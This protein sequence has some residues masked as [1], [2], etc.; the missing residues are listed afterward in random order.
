[1]PAC[2][3][4]PFSLLIQKARA[5][6]AKLKECSQQRLRLDRRDGDDLILSSASLADVFP[7]VQF[8]PTEDTRAFLVELVETLRAAASVRNLAALE[9]VVAAWEATAEIYSDPA[10]LKAAT[11]PL[12]GTDYAEVRVADQ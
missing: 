9:P 7:W 2:T 10:L 4:V 6:V 5:T 11:A 8:L 12:D 3:E 1:M